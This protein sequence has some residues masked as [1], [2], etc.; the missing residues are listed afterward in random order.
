MKRSSSDQIR[1]VLLDMREEYWRNLE[2]VATV[3]A[4]DTRD[5]LVI[6]LGGERFGLD[7]TV[8]REILKLPKL[9]RVPQVPAHVLGVFNL[10]GQ[11]TAVTDLTKLLGLTK[12]DGAQNE[13]LVVVAAEGVTTALRAE[14]VEGIRGISQGSIEPPTPGRFQGSLGGIG[15][16]VLLEDGLLV[17]LDLAALL[18]RPE[19]L[20][21]QKN[22]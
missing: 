1:K 19:L 15:G 6:G 20:V 12:T 21:D 10:R 16:Q 14:R 9:V 11:I 5:Y 13:R 18:R 22:D 8:V 17:L 4:E 2:D 3:L 7:L